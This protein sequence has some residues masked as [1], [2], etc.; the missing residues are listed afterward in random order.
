M[1]LYYI[2]TG[3][4]CGLRRAANIQQARA[5][6]LREVG[7]Y[8]GVKECRL[9]TP[10]DISHVTRMGGYVPPPATRPAREVNDGE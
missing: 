3:L 8:A 10:E 1:A 7:T 5:D 6:A 2:N 9:A 4:G